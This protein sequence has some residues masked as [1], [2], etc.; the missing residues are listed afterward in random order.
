[1]IHLLA[2][3]EVV[4]T[5]DPITPILIPIF[6]LVLIGRF[7]R[8]Q[9]EWAKLKEEARGLKDRLISQIWEIK[10]LTFQRVA[11]QELALSSNEWSGSYVPGSYSYM[12]E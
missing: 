1:M 7:L 10:F 4:P 6:F 3:A 2:M 11:V 9:I 8:E 12:R 5:F